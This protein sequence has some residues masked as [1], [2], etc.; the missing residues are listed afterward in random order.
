MAKVRTGGCLCGAVRYEFAA[1]VTSIQ[2]CHCTMCRRQGGHAQAA[3]AVPRA[4]FRW[5]REDGL[6]WYRSSATARRPFC[7]RCGSALG[8]EED[9]AASV[10]PNV[11]SLDDGGEGLRLGSHIHVASKGAY[12]TI[13]DGLPQFPEGGPDDA[14]T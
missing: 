7:E 3:I 13:D 12:Y 9:G 10:H 2:L 1:D 6:A 4:A 11:G 14:A 8:F 5:T